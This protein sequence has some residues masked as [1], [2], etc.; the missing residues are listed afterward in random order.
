M[1]KMVDKMVDTTSLST[2]YLGNAYVDG[3]QIDVNGGQYVIV[4]LLLRGK[5]VDK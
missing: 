4:H 2:F 1:D 5:R 3:L